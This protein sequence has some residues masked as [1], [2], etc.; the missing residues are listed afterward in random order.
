MLERAEPGS[1]EYDVC[2][3]FAGEQRAFVLNVA[4]LLKDRGLNV[5]YDHDK[6]AALWGTN[7]AAALDL[8]YRKVSRFCVI[9]VSEA[10]ARNV[11]TKH[12]LRSAQARALID[13]SEYLLPVRLDDT[14]LPGLPPTIG[15]VDIAT[16]SDEQLADLIVEKVGGRTPPPADPSPSALLV[17]HEPYVLLGATPLASRNDHLE[18]IMN[19]VEDASPSTFCLWGPGGQ[20]KSA[21]AWEVLQRSDLPRLWHRFMGGSGGYETLSAA[22]CAFASRLGGTRSEDLESAFDRICRTPTL[23]VLDGIE[24]T[25]GESDRLSE[26][27]AFHR[28]IADIRVEGLVRRLI[29]APRVRLL[30]TGRLQPALFDDPGIFPRITRLDLPAIS[31]MDSW[32]F[33]EAMGI[34]GTRVA[35]ASA[36]AAMRG[37]PLLMRLA[38]RELIARAETNIEQWL[39]ANPDFIGAIKDEEEFRLS[40]LLHVMPSPQTRQ[41]QTLLLLAA[42]RTPLSYEEWVSASETLQTDGDSSRTLRMIPG[43]LVARGIVHKKSDKRY[44]MHEIVREALLRSAPAE[45]LNVIYRQL[46][47]QHGSKLYLRGLSGPGIYDEQTTP[48]SISE[49]EPKIGY[50]LSLLDRNL[51]DDAIEVFYSEL[52][53]ALRFR[54][55]ELRVLETLLAEFR[56][57]YQRANGMSDSAH[58][59]LLAEIAVLDC[60]GREA[61][62]LLNPDPTSGESQRLMAEALAQEGRF[63]EAY[64][65]SQHACYEALKHRCIVQAADYTFLQLMSEKPLEDEAYA[66]IGLGLGLRTLGRVLAVGGYRRTALLVMISAAQQVHQSHQPGITSMI[67]E[68]LAHVAL[69]QGRTEQARHFADRAAAEADAMKVW[70]HRINA[71][72]A[73]FRVRGELGDA[74]YLSRH[75]LDAAADAA[76]KGFGQLARDSLH[77]AIDFE[78]AEPSIVETSAFR[79]PPPPERRRH[80]GISLNEE[81]RDLQLLHPPGRWIELELMNWVGRWRE[82]VPAEI[83]S[84]LSEDLLGLD[85]CAAALRTKVVDQT[86]EGFVPALRENEA[87]AKALVELAKCF[88]DGGGI[89]I[90]ELAKKGIYYTPSSRELRQCLIASARRAGKVTEALGELAVLANAQVNTAEIALDIANALREEGDYSLALYMADGGHRACN[91][92]LGSGIVDLAHVIGGGLDLVA[93]TTEPTLVIRAVEGA[94]RGRP[95]VYRYEDKDLT[96][97]LRLMG[98]PPTVSDIP[99]DVSF[100]FANRIQEQQM[101]QSDDEI[102][103]GSLRHLL[104]CGLKRA[105]GIQVSEPSGGEQAIVHSTTVLERIQGHDNLIQEMVRHLKE[106]SDRKLE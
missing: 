6:R 74:A 70:E 71:E 80:D 94:L 23:V 62:P 87:D 35:Y 64:V 14:D 42:S 82:D 83:Q 56:V 79:Y 25:F 53:N 85:D 72:F 43:E 7:V 76:A 69:D 13:G 59:D 60:R 33:W 44:D 81:I 5:F 12:E 67:Y 49:I 30:I 48:T 73:T 4:Q 11:W 20:G 100:D 104:L 57:A 40:A 89:E 93:L 21:L 1:Y 65:A 102:E 55:G 18:M 97:G 68:T 36:A 95:L 51:F 28:S 99:L 24:R 86:S 92:T 38:A 15:Y 22:I 106:W 45:D 88:Q 58:N 84:I 17:A 50:F 19:W 75:L 32:Q 66:L 61:Y 37:S 34:K 31:P 77:L 90:Y 46:D 54:L 2:L 9:F 98:G 101:S 16:T 103:I 91:W 96:G 39:D 3:S 41:W 29:S 26:R 78:L 8:I 47:K 52:F 27:S 63:E 10:Y 105:L